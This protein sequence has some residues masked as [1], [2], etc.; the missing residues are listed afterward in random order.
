MP[1]STR[2][3]PGFLPPSQM[4]A[5]VPSMPALKQMVAMREERWMFFST[6]LPRNAALMPRKKMAR[7]NAHSTLLLEKPM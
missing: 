5:P 1:I 2:T 6:T 4:H 7:L 3:L